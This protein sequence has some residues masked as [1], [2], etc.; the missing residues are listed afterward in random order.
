QLARIVVRFRR[1]VHF[2]QRRDQ[3]PRIVEQRVAG[4]DGCERRWERSLRG[5][6]TFFINGRPV[7]GALPFDLFKQVIDQELKKADDLLAKGT[8]PADLYAAL[9]K[10]GLTKAAAPPPQPGQPDPNTVYKAEVGNSPIRGAKN[11][12]VTIVLWSDFQ[13]PFCGRV[14]PTF[15]Q[16]LDAY[17]KDVRIVWK[18]EPLPFHPNAMPAAEAAMAANEQGKF[19]EFHDKLFSD[20]QKLGTD[21]YDQYAKDL[22]LNMDKFHAAITSHKFKKVIDE[23]SAAG[24]KL[25][26]RGTPTYFINGKVMVG[27]QPF[28]AF[29]T[30]VEAAIK[31][32][33]EG[34]K[35]GTPVAK[36]DDKLIANGK[37]EGAAGPAAS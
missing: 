9:T 10:D 2:L 20:Q 32:A 23:E 16:V 12:K 3:T 13:C 14:E 29:K 19:W 27:A 24:T 33:D 30:R 4:A 37:T 15:K 22:G 21:A 11:A 8:K 18:N 35:K 7:R 31:E 1:H 5:T 28:D 6:P 34:I 26:A 17:P 36:G 25:G